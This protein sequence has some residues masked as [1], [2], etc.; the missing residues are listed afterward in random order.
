MQNQSKTIPILIIILV[1]LVIGVGVFIYFVQT[2]EQENISSNNIEKLENITEECEQLTAE[3]CALREDCYAI[4]TCN[5]ITEIEIARRCGIQSNAQCECDDSN[6]IFC[7]EISCEEDHWVSNEYSITNDE[8]DNV[9]WEQISFINE[10]IGFEMQI[11]LDWETFVWPDKTIR[12]GKDIITSSDYGDENYR[13]NEVRVTWLSPGNFKPTDYIE[14]YRK[15]FEQSNSFIRIEEWDGLVGEMPCNIIDYYMDGFND[16][17]LRKRHIYFARGEY[18]FVIK[19][20][21]SQEWYDKNISDLK[22][23]I[24]SISVTSDTITE[25][26]LTTVKDQVDFTNWNNFRI[27]TKLGYIYYLLG[28]L[29]RA[30]FTP[31]FDLIDY[32]Y[33]VTPHGILFW[34]RGPLYTYTPPAGWSGEPIAYEG[35]TDPEFILFLYDNQQFVTL[36]AISLQSGKERFEKVIGAIVSAIEEK[37]LIDI[38]EYDISSQS[39][40]PGMVWQEPYRSHGLVYDVKTNT[41][42]EDDPLSDFLPIAGIRTLGRTAWD[43]TSSR[44]IWAPGGEGCGSYSVLNY[45]DLEIG[46]YQSIGGEGSYTFDP[47]IVCNPKNDISPD[48]KWFVLYGKSSE[49][50]LDVYLFSFDS[51]PFPI[52]YVKQLPYNTEEEIGYPDYAYLNKWDIS[53]EL[54]AISFDTGQSV[55]F[56]M[57]VEAQQNEFDEPDNLI[58]EI[59]F[60]SCKGIGGYQ[61]NTWFS[62]MEE[63]INK[64]EETYT[65]EDIV[66]ACLS[67]DGKMI[68]LLVTGDDCE[69]IHVY[70]YF[71]GYDNGVW[72]AEEIFQGKECLVSATDFG[73]RQ[74]QI[75]PIKGT[76]VDSGCS[77][78]MDY[79]YNIRQHILELKRETVQCE[80]QDVQII[81]Y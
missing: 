9:V 5:C 50:L 35:G 53:N 80:G 56:R 29:E 37:M 81:D 2:N 11:P 54:P 8:P 58:T 51:V 31:S 18:T 25:Y 22:R 45:A 60:D 36:P 57:S 17:V 49:E 61:S 68:I 28:D 20:A 3:A 10:S 12:G 41:F 69:G 67:L 21:G 65:I 73:K 40:Q 48:G 4:S 32:W 76:G 30:I 70:K 74:G 59:V 38:G 52:R 55:D 34:K 72:K 75:I 13:I 27:D 33:Q 23:I 16:S 15:S 42:E 66:D 63:W 19:I 46:T 39:F 77:S 7:S 78:V 79:E 24:G 71:I 44:F 26:Q 1:I 64:Y 43:S 47:D 6:Y 14:K 62:N